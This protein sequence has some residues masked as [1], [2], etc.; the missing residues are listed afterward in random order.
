[1]A[2]PIN[3][4]LYI[5]NLRL[6]IY[7]LF[8]VDPLNSAGELGGVLTSAQVEAWVSTHSGSIDATGRVIDASLAD[9]ALA[10]M[11]LRRRRVDR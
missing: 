6:I 2:E 10:Q 7:N 9:A 4:E 3:P 11:M 8:D 5:Y 1:L